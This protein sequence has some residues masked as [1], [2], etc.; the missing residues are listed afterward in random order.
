MRGILLGKD[1]ET[2]GHVRL[3]H[4]SF[5]THYHLIGGTG[6]GKTT[7]LHTILYPLLLYLSNT[8]V[9]IFDR[10][11]RTAYATDQIFDQ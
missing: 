11:A 1:I 10:L 2:G 8:S 6:K 5:T 7:A 4:S 9:F 3:P